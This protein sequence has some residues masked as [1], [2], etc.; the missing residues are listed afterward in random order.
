MQQDKKVD[1]P[2]N[3]VEQEPTLSRSAKLVLAVF[4]VLLMTLFFLMWKGLGVG[5]I[6][7]PRS[8]L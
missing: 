7:T 6:I 2:Q 1:P 3:E 4:M 8:S 5:P